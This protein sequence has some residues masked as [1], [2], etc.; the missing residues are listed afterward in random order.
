MRAQFRNRIRI[1]LAIIILIAL[2]VLTRLYFLQIV[3]GQEYAQ[4][5]SQQFSSGGGGPFDRGTIFFTRK[6]G[7]LISAATLATGFLVAIDPQEI[8]DPEAAYAA[9]D[10]AASS[11]VITH[12]AFLADAADKTRVYIEVAHQLSDAA[13][14]ALAALAIPGVQVLRE[15]WRYYPGGSLAAQ[16]IGIMSYGSGS[17]PVGQTGLE[18]TYNDVLSRSGDT[19]QKNFFAELFSNAGNLLVNT[20]NAHEGDVVTTIE[21]E[22]QM[23]LEDDIAAVNQKYSSQ[24]S[25]GIIMDP[26]TGAIYALA[27][28]PTFDPNNLQN[29]DPSL[30]VNPLLENVFEYGSIMKPITMASALTAGVVTPQTTYDDTGCIKVDNDRICNWNFKAYG[31]I[32]MLTIIEDSLNVG[33]SWVAQQLGQSQFR[34]YFTNI[35]GQKTG[36]DLP[37]ESDALIGNLLKPQQI[38]YDTAS[39]GEGIAVTPLQMIRALA[40]VA[41]GGILVHP[42]L[43]SRIILTSGVSEPIDWGSGTRIFSAAASRE[44]TVMMDALWDDA[45]KVNGVSAKIPTMSV[46]AKTGTAQLPTPTGTYYNNKFFNSEVAFFPSFNPRFIILLYTKDPKNVIYA[47]QSLSPSL[48]DLVHFLINYY[49]VPPDRGL[50]ATTTP[51]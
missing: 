12:A 10:A 7:T 39:F 17:V 43:A 45:L 13:G 1:V 44:T 50:A 30:L 36:I 33:A 34:Q 28:F 6:D 24:E 3:R 48:L 35:F 47:E 42:H 32:P 15:N 40:A 46:A 16:S 2:G 5:A 20:Q 23:R 37:H 11:T 21:P 19:L 14:N 49:A 41:N 18:A 26:K 51:Q 8:T 31:V 4:K 9:I 25:G 27:S 38:Y 22:V 29:L